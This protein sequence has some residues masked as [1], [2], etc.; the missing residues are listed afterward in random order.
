MAEGDRLLVAVL[1]DMIQAQRRLCLTLKTRA[2]LR[3]GEGAW[4]AA[5]SDITLMLKIAEHASH[6]RFLVEGLVALACRN[7]ALDALQALILDERID[8]ARLTRYRAEFAQAD[9][10]IRMVDAL[11]EGERL[12]FLNTVVV[13]AEYGIDM[14]WVAGAGNKK[15][16]NPWIRKAY[17]F[18]L[19]LRR[20][21]GLYDRIV[22]A[23]RTDDRRAIKTFQSELDAEFKKSAKLGDGPLNVLA[24]AF[25]TKTQRSELLFDTLAALFTPAFE[26]TMHAEVRGR[27]RADFTDAA[28]ALALYRKR[29]GRF[30]AKFEELRPEFLKTLTADRFVDRP[31]TY[32]SDGKGFILYSVGHDERDD[33]GHE[34]L[35]EDVSLYTPDFKP[36]PPAEDEPLPD[37]P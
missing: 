5:W 6:P 2:M 31:L 11:D 9:P 7:L 19:L 16:S 8:A 33:E 24:L 28:F 21:N 14:T 15:T 13:W 36:K 32:K 17:D 37:L 25:A 27:Q 10:K 12:F 34:E 30:P 3:I 4:D 26:A 22:K 18:D 23:Y 35:N 20:G 1:L 29:H